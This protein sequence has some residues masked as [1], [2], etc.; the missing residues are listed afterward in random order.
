MEMR[1]RGRG[2]FRGEVRV[3]GDKSIS[4]R[5][6]ILGALASGVTRAKGFSWAG[7]CLST[8]RCLSALGV[9]WQREGDDLVVEGA[10]GKW[11]EPEGVLY[12]G[13]SGTTMRLL[14]GVLAWQEGFFVLTGDSSLRRRPMGRVTAPLSRMGASVWGRGGGEFPPLAVKGEGAS[15]AGG[16]FPLPVPSAQVKSA[17]LL[18][19]LGAR[20]EVTVEEPSLSRDHTER[21]LPFFGVP[22]K[23]E[24]TRVSLSGPVLPRG[25][26]TLEIPGD[27]SSAAFFFVLAA[28]RPGSAVTVRGVGLNPGRTGLLE[29]LEEMG[30]RVKREN[31]REEAGEP[32]GDVTVEGDGLRAVS[33]GGELIPRLLD[34]LPVLGVALACAEGQS[35]VRG[36]SELRV[37]ESD[38]L[39]G[40][41]ELLSR[42]GAE[43]EELEDGFRV[44]GPARLEGCRIFPC[45]DHRLA[46][47]GAV[48]G[49]LA[50][51]ETVVEDARLCHI[52]FPG[53]FDELSKFAELSENSLA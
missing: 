11:V 42:F 46:M 1:I 23:R 32:V 52:S 38:R 18:A 13:N 15:L 25:G 21:M 39:R 28:C 14:L 12:C 6:A 16:E 49:A 31:V 24:G 45:G 53:F 8:L 2:P 33:L 37:K 36:A 47:A 44:R 19:G 20:G 29:V 17:L 7:D 40:T 3:P 10:A 48:A 5:A 51:G 22:V 50:G 30:A 9:R 43:A 26:G 4:H 27:I 34:E 35:E 41:V